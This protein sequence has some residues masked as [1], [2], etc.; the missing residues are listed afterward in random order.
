MYFEKSSSN[1]IILYWAREDNIMLNVKL[2]N[3]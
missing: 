2:E 1:Q 3:F